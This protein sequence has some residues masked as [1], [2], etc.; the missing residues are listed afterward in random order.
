MTQRAEAGFFQHYLRRIEL[1]HHLQQEAHLPSEHFTQEP[2]LLEQP[3]QLLQLS[4]ADTVANPSPAMRAS[5]APALI[6]VFM[7]VVCFVKSGNHS[8]SKSNS[9]HSAKSP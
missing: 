3:W 9:P 6:N 2:Q 1:S 4:A 8:R 5:M 7:C